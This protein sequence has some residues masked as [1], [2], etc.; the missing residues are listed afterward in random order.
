[1][2]LNYDLELPGEYK[3]SW[4]VST[5]EQIHSVKTAKKNSYSV[6]SS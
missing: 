1:M 3:T 2:L 6:K 4:C 5:I